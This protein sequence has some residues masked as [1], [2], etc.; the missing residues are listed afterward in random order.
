MVRGAIDL[1]KLVIVIA[2]EGAAR[3]PEVTTLNGIAVNLR[4]L[5]TNDLGM[6]AESFEILR[7]SPRRTIRAMGAESYGLM[8]LRAGER[9]VGLDRLDQAW[10]EYDQMG[11]LGRRAT[12]Q[13][14]MRQ[15][16]VRRTKWSATKSGS[17]HK[18]L[19][20]AERR[21]VYLIAD[22]HTNK[23]AARALGIS[24]LTVGTHIRSAYS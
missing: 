22:G 20:E 1:M 15:A 9:Q 6:V 19:T 13:L 12:V 8:L 7:D 23:S 5:F 17:D 11:A 4:G 3:N 18:P 2:E 21:V 14:V 10:D 16:G 24:V